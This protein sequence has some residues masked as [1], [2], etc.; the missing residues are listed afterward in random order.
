MTIA[1]AK[2]P[3]STVE[4]AETGSRGLSPGKRWAFRAA[5]VLVG[6]IGAFLVGEVFLRVTGIGPPRLRTKQMLKA[7]DGSSY[8]CYTSNPIGEF[9]P[10]PDMSRGRWTALDYSIPPVEI[11]FEQ[12]ADTPWCVSYRFNGMG[13]RDRDYAEKPG[14][15]IRR[16]I[17]IGDSFVFGEGVPISRCLFKQMEMFAGPD[18]EIVNAG[19]VGVDLEHEARELPKLTRHLNADRAILVVIANDVKLSEPMIKRHQQ[20]NDLIMIRDKALHAHEEAQWFAGSLRVLEVIGTFLDR[21]RVTAQTIRWYQDAYDPAWNQVGL[22]AMSA[23]FDAIA[24]CRSFRT[25]IVIYPLLEGL[26]GD[27]PLAGVHRT[28]ARIAASHGLPV[29]DLAPH[30]KGLSPSSLWV[31]PSDHHPNGK[32]HAIAARAILEWLS[33]ELP[34]FLEGASGPDK[35]VTSR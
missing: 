1:A 34:W 7:E 5:A 31:H 23:S 25:A 6:L 11:P 8:H 15:N 30:F 29:F 32:A 10:L 4:N 18:L 12:M 24:R 14:V 20:I 33:A 26:Q 22:D 21:R 3:E 35:P 13:I 9:R 28:I 19:F 16:V 17:G 2:T 27:Y